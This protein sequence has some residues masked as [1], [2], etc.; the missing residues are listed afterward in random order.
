MKIN[1]NEYHFKPTKMT[2][3]KKII[4]YVDKDAEN[5]EP[6]YIAGGI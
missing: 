5:L 2:I 4:A 1:H 6:S 3:I